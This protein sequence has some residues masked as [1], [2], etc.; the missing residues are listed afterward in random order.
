MLASLT[1]TH[2]F[3]SG[4]REQ[5]APKNAESI[6]SIE[7]KFSGNSDQ[8]S[9]HSHSK[10]EQGN[11]VED[12]KDE[13]YSQ[14]LE[15]AKAALVAT[16]P[17]SIWNKAMASPFR[18]WLWKEREISIVDGYVVPKCC[19]LKHDVPWCH[20]NVTMQ[21]CYQWRSSIKPFEIHFL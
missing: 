17:H 3:S 4:I 6:Q 7:A 14:E 21:L 18:Q 19:D 13:E 11:L 20:E 2:S 1:R 5:K 12:I 15:I 8:K 16:K 10:M 9:P